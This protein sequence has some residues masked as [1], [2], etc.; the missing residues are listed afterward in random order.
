MNLKDFSTL[1]IK[2]PSPHAKKEFKNIN[3]TAQ[4]MLGE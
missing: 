4:V 1:N 3:Q 2:R